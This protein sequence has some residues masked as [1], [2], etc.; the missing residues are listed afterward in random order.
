MVRGDFCGEREKPKRY[1]LERNQK[2]KTTYK[3]KAV[4]LFT[5]TSALSRPSTK[6]EQL[7]TDC[8]HPKIILKK[9]RGGRAPDSTACLLGGRMKSGVPWVVGRGPLLV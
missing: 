4:N 8:C 6:C 1:L 5:K 9:R 7:H 3:Q 2:Q